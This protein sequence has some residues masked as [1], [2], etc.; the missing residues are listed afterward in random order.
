MVIV[1]QYSH[2]GPYAN[3]RV[4]CLYTGGMPACVIVFILAAVA[5]ALAG[6]TPEAFAA[7]PAGVRGFA[8]TN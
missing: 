6:A 8:V 3:G 2:A 1:L 5:A 4:R 7:L